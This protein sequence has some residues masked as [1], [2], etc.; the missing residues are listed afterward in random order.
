MR[1]QV[2][3]LVVD[4]HA[5]FCDMVKEIVDLSGH[6]FE[7]TCE[8]AANKEAASLLM[9]TFEPSVV[10]LDAHLEDG[11]SMQCLSDWKHLPAQVV[12]TSV[13][14]SPGIEK[15]ARNGGASGYCPKSSKL[16]DVERL[17]HE[18]AEMAGDTYRIH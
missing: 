6:I 18:L 3:L 8:F 7:I 9:N 5:E 12:V 1:K 10:L 4:D 2:R 11:N 13:R 17:V 14:N 16:E 15:A